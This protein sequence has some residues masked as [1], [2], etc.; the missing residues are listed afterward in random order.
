MLERLRMEVQ[1]YFRVFYPEL[2]RLM[3]EHEDADLPYWFGG[4]REIETYACTD[5]VA[6]VHVPYN[7]E[8]LT[9]PEREDSFNFNRSPAANGQSVKEL[10]RNSFATTSLEVIP[11]DWPCGDF[12]HYLRRWP[13]YV[14]YPAGDDADLGV[15]SDWTRLEVASVSYLH[16]WRDA[17]SARADA[18]ETVRP[19][20]EEDD[21]DKLPVPR[22]L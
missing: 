11:A 22:P 19:Y 12:G 4:G 17:E 18:W 15:L 3:S 20:V 5:G 1:D 13:A 7:P 2:R 8:T 14:G 10:V 21:N 9:F 6:I 16:V